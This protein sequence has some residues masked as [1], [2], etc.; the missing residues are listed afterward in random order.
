MACWPACG[1]A[2]KVA[3]LRFR[4]NKRGLR[5]EPRPIDPEAEQPRELIAPGLRFAH[6]MTREP[7]TVAHTTTSQLVSGIARV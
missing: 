4:D 6:A 1:P 7:R 2:V 3:A 5:L